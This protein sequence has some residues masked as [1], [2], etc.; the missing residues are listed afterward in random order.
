MKIKENATQ[1][2]QMLKSGEIEE[3]VWSR[4]TSWYKWEKDEVELKANVEKLFEKKLMTLFYYLELKL[5]RLPTQTEYRKEYLRIGMAKAKKQDWYL[6]NQDY[7]INACL[8]WR[9][10]RAYKS[11]LIEVMTAMQLQTKG[12]TVLMNKYVDTIAGVD[13]V[14]IKDSK[15]WYIHITKDSKWAREKVLTKGT[16]R[17][18][19]V[20]GKNFKF[21]RDFENHVELFY[22]NDENDNN[23]VKSGL[24]LFRFEYLDRKLGNYNS[25][26]WDCEENQIAKLLHVMKNAGALTWNCEWTSN[27]NKMVLK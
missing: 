24:P 17:D 3:K 9:A 7:F 16:Y 4:E 14:A 10:D 2:M 11:S 12:Y 5:K 1:I 26:E 22:S 13:L 15:V 25:Q 8:E 27:D 20:N 23:T 19:W 18:Y 6:G 21:E